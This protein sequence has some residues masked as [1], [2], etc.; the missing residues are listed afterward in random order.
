MATLGSPCEGEPQGEP[1]D[2]IF[3][4]TA[5]ALLEA[6]AAAL[7]SDCWKGETFV[8][9]GPPSPP[10]GVP[11]GPD[12]LAV[13]VMDG[14][15]SETAFQGGTGQVRL[16]TAHFGLQLN[17]G[18]W[19]TVQTNNAQVEY[20]SVDA[21]VRATR[22][23]HHWRCVAHGATSDWLLSTRRG[24][25]KVDRLGRFIAVE[26]GGGYVGWRWEVTVGL[27]SSRTTPTP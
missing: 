15:P 8:S 16:P 6:V 5:A 10:L 13:W 2:D 17:L 11:C 18:C 1:T 9:I 25:S 7:A 20:P 14:G 23:A 21:Q 19:P 4:R 26:P 27:H 3:Y 24:S 22:W 12:Q